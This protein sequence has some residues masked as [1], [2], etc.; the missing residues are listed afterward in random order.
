M[1]T[2]RKLHQQRL[3]EHWVS[4]RRALLHQSGRPTSPS[5]PSPLPPP[6]HSP[7]AFP[8]GLWVLRLP[9]R[10][11]F[12]TGSFILSHPVGNQSKN[13]PGLAALLGVRGCRLASVSLNHH[14]RGR[15]CRE[16][17]RGGLFGRCVLWC[18]SAL[19]GLRWLRSRGRDIWYVSIFFFISIE[20]GQP[21]AN[22]FTVYKKV[23]GGLS[24]RDVIGSCR[25]HQD[26]G[27]RR[28]PIFGITVRKSFFDAGL[29]WE[30][31]YVTGVRVDNLSALPWFRSSES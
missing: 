5:L 15:S 22:P 23:R 10:Q 31:R 3:A 18:H 11:H 13:C 25:L 12:D 29:F 26:T 20:H 30:S 4:V 1:T 17:F 16:Q 7:F 24:L 8:G 9:P 28:A 14:S 2:P 21:G 19:L 6:T 27:S